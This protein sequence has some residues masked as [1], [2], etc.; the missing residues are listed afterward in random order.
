MFV[1]VSLYPL[2]NAFPRDGFPG[3]L[4]ALCCSGKPEQRGDTRLIMAGR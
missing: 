2:G 4:A 3:N 1:P